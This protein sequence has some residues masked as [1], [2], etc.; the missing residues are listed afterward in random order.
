MW[1][2]VNVPQEVTW[3]LY[4][5]SRLP[6]LDDRWVV[7][8]SASR[9]WFN[10]RHL[11]NSL[12]VYEIVKD[13]GIADDHIIF[14]NAYDSCDCRNVNNSYF[15]NDASIDKIYLNNLY[16]ND[17]KIDYRN[18]EVTVDNFIRLLTNRFGGSNLR[19]NMNAA[20]KRLLSDYRSNVLVFLSGHG[21]DEFF[22]FQDREELTAHA[23]AYIFDDMH[24]KRMYRQIL[25]IVD[26]CQAETLGKY[27]TAPNVTFISSSIKGEN[28]YAY[29]TDPVVGVS[30]IDRFSLSLNRFFNSD[31]STRPSSADNEYKEIGTVG[32]RLA[33]SSTLEAFVKFMDRRHLYST[34]NFKVSSSPDGSPLQVLRNL[35]IADF[36]SDEITVDR[37]V[38][39]SAV[40]RD[41]SVDYAK[42]MSDPAL[43]PSGIVGGGGSARG[44]TK[45][46]ITFHKYNFEE[47]NSTIDSVGLVHHSC[48]ELYI[49]LLL[50]FFFVLL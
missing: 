23:L 20:R 42:D 47:A 29:E 22:K 3:Q 32:S 9:Y 34:A 26:T 18:D 49:L 48:T 4:V 12:T 28:S 1:T 37:Y 21:G 35:L 24:A 46:D 11:T 39:V 33:L 40:S 7:L 41:T 17:I 13:H 36:F 44:S 45:A 27:I 16:K 8:V 5:P 38:V 14:M 10:Y 50:I 25:L 6:M 30:L 15:F 43:N 31:K 19:Q 2:V